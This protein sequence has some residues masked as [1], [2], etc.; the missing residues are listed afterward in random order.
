MKNVMSEVMGH[1]K[2]QLF[3]ECLQGIHQEDTCFAHLTGEKTKIQ[4]D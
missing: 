3:D 4:R 2:E 1:Q